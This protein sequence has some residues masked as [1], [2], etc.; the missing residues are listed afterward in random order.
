M[1]AMILAAGHG[2]RMRPLTNITPKPLLEAGGK[3]L[4]VWHIERLKKSGIKEFIINLGWLGH[5]I[6]QALGDGSQWGVHIHYSDEQQNGPLETAGGIIQALPLLGNEPFIVV[7]GDVWCDIEY[8]HPILNKHN[9]AH[10]ILVKNPI[11]NLKGDF[12]LQ[13]KK[14]YNTGQPSYT[15]S[16]IGYY[17]PQLF[18]NQTQGKAPL[19]PLL[20]EAIN[21]ELVSGR[22]FQGDWR[23]IGTP[24]RLKILNND[25]ATAKIHAPAP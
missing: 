7:N 11:H 19:T 21:Q 9:L 1:K 8:Q 6:P 3:P 10:L 5:K 20:R 25:L 4:I 22:Y 2:K 18:A 15:F 14:L 17:H 24:D 23:D 13:E 12:C 16:G